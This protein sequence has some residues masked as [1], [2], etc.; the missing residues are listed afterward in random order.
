[1]N[2]TRSPLDDTKTKQLQWYGHVQRMEKEDRQKKLCNG[3]HRKEEN[4]IDLNP[5]GWKGLKD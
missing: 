5:P 2:V 3:V 1:M 4:E